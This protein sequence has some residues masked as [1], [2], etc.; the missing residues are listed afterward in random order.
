[1]K[2]HV[3][4]TAVD[5]RSFSRNGCSPLIIAITQ[6]DDRVELLN[7]CLKQG[8]NDFV[9]ALISEFDWARYLTPWPY[10]ALNEGQRDFGGDAEQ[11]L[12][13]LEDKIIPSIRSSCQ[14]FGVQISDIY[15]TGYSLGGLFAVY[16]AINSDAFKRI[17]CVSGSLW[18]PYFKEHLADNKISGHIDRIYLSLGDKE[19]Q[20]NDSLLSTVR[21]K[22]DQIYAI[23]AKQTDV[24]YELNPGNHFTQT[25]ARLAKGIAWISK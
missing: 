24:Y 14:N 21:L 23:L 11:F 18:Y 20:S 2:Y 3:E 5:I 13:F 1:M 8:C 17:A 9:L 4:G 19:A 22:T 10:P 15:L 16:A 25:A 7:E 6:E 12:K